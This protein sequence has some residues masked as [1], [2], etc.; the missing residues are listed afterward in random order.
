MEIVV[1][2]KKPAETTFPFTVP[3]YKQRT[4]SVKALVPVWRRT[5]QEFL[6]NAIVDARI[7]PDVLKLLETL[8]RLQMLDEMD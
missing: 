3:V 4:Q 7:S 5:E 2:V 8:L 1:A 6:V